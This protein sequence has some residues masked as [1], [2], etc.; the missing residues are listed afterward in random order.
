MITNRIWSRS[1][2]FGAI[3]AAV[4]M[5][6]TAHIAAAAA[7][8]T[9]EPSR[10]ASHLSAAPDFALPDTTS[11]L[12]RLS[13]F[14]GRRVALFFYCGCEWCH[15]CAR[16]WGEMQRAGA[17]A[18]LPVPAKN[19]PIT[20]VVFQGDAGEAKQFEA[21]TGMDSAQTVLLTD[22]SMHVTLDLYHA[23]VCPRVFVLDRHGY[24]DY[25][26][27]HVDDLPRKAP[28]QVIATRALKALRTP[29]NQTEP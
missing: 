9:G 22:E 23:A 28:E 7:A 5:G 15:R 1:I 11:R 29:S 27:D 2:A 17:L 18:S 4:A 16:V 12:R 14:R 6:C 10:Q 8:R 25:T 26:N 13:E 21:Q 3:T 24:L 20:V 19:S